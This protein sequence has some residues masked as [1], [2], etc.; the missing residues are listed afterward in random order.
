MSGPLPSNT[1]VPEG[2][3]IDGTTYTFQ[4]AGGFT[5]LVTD[6]FLAV[7]PPNTL[8]VNRG[9]A[10]FFSAGDAVTLTFAAP[11]QAIGAYFS[12]SGAAGTAQGFL[13]IFTPAGT[14]LNGDALPAGTFGFPPTCSSSR[15]SGG[16][17]PTRTA[18]RPIR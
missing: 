13:S 9:G 6:A 16:R 8:G 3:I 11:I 12:S 5:G 2:G 1:V 15:E 18:P 10:N 4:V 17:S 7:S 14:A